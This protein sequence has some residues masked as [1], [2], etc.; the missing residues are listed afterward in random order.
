MRF[1]TWRSV[2]VFGAVIALVV[3]LPGSLLAQSVVSGDITGTVTDPSGAVVSGATVN[4]KS[5]DTG[6]NLTD[7]TS[8]GGG[9]RFPLLKPGRYTVTIAHS[10]FKGYS[11]T[12]TVAVGQ[13]TTLAVKLEIGSQGEVVEVTGE[14]SVLQTESSEITTSFGATQLANAPNPGGDLTFVAQTAPGVLM[15]TQGGYGNFSAFGLPA[16]SNVFTVNGMNEMDPY[17]NLTT[18]ARPTSCWA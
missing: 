6:L 17:L 4:L 9:F 1:D 10:G 11:Q 8:Q 16:D 5:A 13:A 12:I 7:T 14:G 3:I 15:N 2:F 18:Q